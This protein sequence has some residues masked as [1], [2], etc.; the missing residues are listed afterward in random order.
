MKKLLSL[1]FLFSPLYCYEVTQ[2]TKQLSDTSRQIN[3]TFTLAD[4]EYLYT[5]SILPSVNNPDVTLT[6][7]EAN[8]QPVSFF[9][10]TFQKQK[11]GYTGT[12]TFSGRATLKP[13]AKEATAL[14]H[15]HFMVSSDQQ[16]KEVLTE[17][18]FTLPKKAP[19]PAQKA[20]PTKQAA[21]QNAPIDC[22]PQQPSLFGNFIQKLLNY[23]SLTVT[24]ARATVT[25]LFSDTG[26]KVIRILAAFLLGILL[27]LT[28][29]IYPMIPITI[30]ILQASG[31]TSAKR[32]FLLAFSYTLGIS[33]TFALLGF[34]A[35]VGSCVFGEVQ[36]SP[37]F[38]IPLALLLLFLGLTM[39][40][41]VN[42]PI[43]KWLQPK[44]SKISGGSLRSAFIFGA[45]SG[46]VASPCLSPGLILI[47]N[48]VAKI[49]TM[50]LGAY[51]EGFALLFM[52]GIGSSLPL[53]IIG[54]FSGSLSKLPKAGAWM[55]E[56]KKLIGIMLIAMA[57][58]QLS[59]LERILP[60]Y[61][62]IWVIV[63]VFVILG[64]YYFYSI[65]QY[66][67][68]G[69][70]RYKNTMGASLIVIGAVLGVQG[71]KA[72][73]EH[74]FPDEVAQTWSHSYQSSVDK[75]RKENKLL[76]IDIGATYCSTCKLLDKTIFAQESIQ[77]A[78]ALFTLLKI[79]SDVDTQAYEE[80]KEHYKKYIVG[81]PTY[82]VVD[83][84]TNTVLKKWTIDIDQMTLEGIE[85]ELRA[86][87]QQEG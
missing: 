30:G 29:C 38:V 25:G 12:V 21:Q 57:L 36:G 53:L 39:F 40:D 20:A 85:Q 37:Y 55:I 7:L 61:I 73:L 19:A 68:K 84:T 69:M 77:D 67:S 16:P 71:E 35:A 87:A 72:L 52:F 28:P 66:D 79:E 80:V 86:L 2:S 34:I 8:T 22:E 70:K 59:H 4:K 33:T 15:T 81:F 62:F 5:D 60:W 74:L 63:L 45:L 17:L 10:E 32:N 64:T 26:S 82:L 14:V 9:D 83:P 48:Y 23:I 6:P 46:T 75:A 65:K 18:S 58:F 44:D 76:F 43:P 54:T 13:E 42:M 1:L 41:L 27:S 11:E 24:H 78:L 51:L 50:S 49:S 47:L 31:S 56:I 3:L